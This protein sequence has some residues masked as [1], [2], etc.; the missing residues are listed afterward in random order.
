MFSLM[1]SV[2]FKEII[3]FNCMNNCRICNWTIISDSVSV[4]AVDGVNTLVI[5]IP[6]GTY[7]NGY[8]YCIIVA[9][10]IPDT[11][12]INMPVAISIGGVTTTVYPFTNINGLQLTAS[13]ISTRT[14]YPVVVVTN[15]TTGIFRSLRPIWSAYNN[16]RLA[17]I[18][19][20]VEATTTGETSATSAVR[21]STTA[22]AVK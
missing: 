21:K 18:P 15:A 2:D 12:T 4:V 20:V 1:P 3:M 19:V 16:T 11:A 10:A 7:Y 8:Q 14:R 5:D 9:Q 22:S 17:S 13:D 6:A